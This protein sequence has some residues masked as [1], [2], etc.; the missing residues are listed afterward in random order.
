MILANRGWLG[1]AAWVYVGLALVASFGLVSANGLF[2]E[3]ALALAVP[4]FV[5]GL[6]FNRR[7]IAALTILEIVGVAGRAC[8]RGGSPRRFFFSACPA[9]PVGSR[10]GAMVVGQP[11][12]A[13]LGQV[14]DIRQQI[15]AQHASQPSTGQARKTA[16]SRPLPV[17]QRLRPAGSVYL[18][19]WI[20]RHSGPTPVGMAP[21]IVLEGRSVSLAAIAPDAVKK[22]STVARDH[23]RMCAAASAGTNSQL[24]QPVT[25]G[26][27]SS[28]CS[29]ASLRRP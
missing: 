17:D 10:R 5:A 1:V 9:M 20:A 7:S 2:T 15:K 8:P 26:M 25:Y 13:S 12:R 28:G 27:R 4:V 24:I 16:S 23:W 6:L 19:G 21:A 14:E 22:K 18:R 29:I 3:S 11:V